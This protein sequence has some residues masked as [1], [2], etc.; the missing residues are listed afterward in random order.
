MS[1]FYITEPKELINLNEQKKIINDSILEKTSMNN[2]KNNLMNEIIR[3]KE[4]NNNLFNRLK[5]IL[6][7]NDQI[8]KT[9][10]RKDKI[11]GVLRKNKRNIERSLN[12]FNTNSTLN[13]SNLNV[14]VHS[15]MIGGFS[16]DNNNS[17]FM[18]KSAI[19]YS[20]QTNNNLNLSN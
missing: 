9:V 5:T 6:E 19:T 12:S 8:K 13:N 15:A 17:P 16:K 18:D 1:I 11:N 14:T 7:A 3:L 4:Q 2:D 20:P 10:D